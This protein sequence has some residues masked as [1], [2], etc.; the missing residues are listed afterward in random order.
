MIRLHET[1]L[2][3]FLSLFSLVNYNISYFWQ[4]YGYLSQQ[5][6]MMQVKEMT[7]FIDYCVMLGVCFLHVKSNR[8]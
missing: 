4:F 7:S 6:N 2:S 1:T 5:Q 3:I 8:G